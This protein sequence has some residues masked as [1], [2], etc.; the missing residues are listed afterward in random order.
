[1]SCHFLLQGIFLDQ[2]LNACLLHRQADSLLLSHLGSP[3]ICQSPIRALKF[4]VLQKLV[5][6]TKQAP[7]SPASSVSELSRP[8]GAPTKPL[9]YKHFL[10]FQRPVCTVSRSCARRVSA[11]LDS[12][13]CL[14]DLS[15]PPGLSW[16]GWVRR[17]RDRGC[18]GP[19]VLGCLRADVALL[20]GNFQ[21]KS[22]PTG[23]SKQEK[24][25]LWQREVQGQGVPREGPSCP[26]KPLG[27]ACSPGGSWLRPCL[28]FLPPALPGSCSFFSCEDPCP[29]T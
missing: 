26:S 11:S 10:M 6:Q 27:F 12:A 1:M 13:W 22:P 23:G 16:P 8:R 3:Y 15:P 21:S 20:P 19:T 25:V 14:P 18:L 28:P 17:S 4:Q 7:P 9:A 29:W 2:G 5:F 24:L